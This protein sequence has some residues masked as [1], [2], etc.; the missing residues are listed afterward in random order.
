[1]VAYRDIDAQRYG[2]ITADQVVDASF[3]TKIRAASGK[4]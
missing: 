2:S 3:M 1:L 4:S